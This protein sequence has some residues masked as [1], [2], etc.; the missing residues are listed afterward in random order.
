VP[1]TGRWQGLPDE[2]VVVDEPQVRRNRSL[3]IEQDFQIPRMVSHGQ[4]ALTADN[5]AFQAWV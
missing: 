2:R 3:V 5:A 1:S 4:L